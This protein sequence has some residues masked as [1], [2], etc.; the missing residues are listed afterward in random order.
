MKRKRQSGKGYGRPSH[1]K[2]FMVQEATG[3][4]LKNNLIFIKR[5]ARFPKIG[6][7]FPL[8]DSP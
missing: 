4:V 1:Q 7:F 3:L 2:P 8:G 5:S 6:S